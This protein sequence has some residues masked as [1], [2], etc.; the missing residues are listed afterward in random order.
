MSL[1]MEPIISPVSADLIA[2]ELTKDKFL[3]DTNKGRNEIYIF[4]ANEAP[5]TMR[6]VGRLREVVF[7]ESGGGSGLA[8]DVDEFD[9]Q[10]PGYYQL[11]VWNPEA[12]VIVGGYR[13]ITG[14]T[15]TH[16]PKPTSYL[17]T[18]HMFNYSDTFVR[19]YL[20][21]TIELG[22]SFVSPEFQST[23]FH[24]L[25]IFALDNLWDGLGALMVLRPNIE[26]FF[27]KVTMYASYNRD[28]RD[29]ILNFMARHFLDDKNLV[30]PKDPLPYGGNPEV[31]DA[32]FSSGVLSEDYKA[33]KQ[34]VRK[35][36]FNI[37]PLFNSYLS[38]C[39]NM[40]FLGSAINHEFSG[41]EE[42][43]ILLKISD[44]YEEKKDRHIHSFAKS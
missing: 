10:H 28:C 32:V 15:I 38:L 41:V 25:S 6:E 2:A 13:Y 12:R 43:A 3:R 22:R 16:L 8:C 4:H 37:P 24:H 20:P 34:A 23:R 17:A 9:L 19:D 21:Y 26:Y 42:S 5:N 33:L 44:I 36:G 7:R 14:D 30:T 11:V 39:P 1:R 18:S 40:L 35:I 27:G 31:M 29:L